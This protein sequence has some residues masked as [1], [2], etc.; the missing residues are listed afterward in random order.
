M[1]RSLL[2]LL[3]LLT[4]PLAGFFLAAPNLVG[5]GFLVIANQREHTLV[6]FDLAER[7]TVASV[8]VGVNG[9][10]VVVSPDGKFAYVP[11]YGN[12]GVGKPGTDGQFIDVIDLHT[13]AI[14]G[15]IDLGKPVRPHCAKFGPDGLLYVSAELANAVF[16]VDTS[17]RKV[18][19][20]IP[21]GAE[22][23]HMFV[24]SP[25]GKR[26]YTSNVSAGT[27]SVLDLQKRSLVTVIPV[28]KSVQ[29]ISISPDGRHV[30]THDQNQPRIAVIDTLTNT[31]T[32][33]I[34]LPDTVYSSAVL[35]DGVTLVAASPS[36]KMFVIDTEKSKIVATVA[37]PPSSGEIIVTPDGYRVFLSCPQDGTIQFLDHLVAKQPALEAP[38]ALSKGVDGLAWIDSL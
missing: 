29:R 5:P 10:E 34:S 11:I 24:I 12:S 33:Y 23:S 35:G 22:Q 18:I 17:T 31:V 38:I 4:I 7:T 30:Y 19:A 20:E 16:V 9:H 3:P 36:G 6:L 21:T 26:A 1:Y 25:D 14:A 2:I 28:A 37:V 27:V 8:E 13:H 32:S 15:H